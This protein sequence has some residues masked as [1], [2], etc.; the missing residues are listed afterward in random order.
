[1]ANNSAK[2]VIH[3]SWSI[4]SLYI[5][6]IRSFLY[7]TDSVYDGQISLVPTRPFYTKFTVG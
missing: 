5:V 6:S 2:N 7:I 3:L 4:F 1:M